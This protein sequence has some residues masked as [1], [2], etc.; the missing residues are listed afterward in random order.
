MRFLIAHNEYGAVSG[1]EHAI[2]AIAALLAKNGNN[3][4]WF[5][6]SSAEIRGVPGKIRAFVS[7]IHSHESVRGMRKFLNGWPADI[8]IVQNL[9]PFLSP[10]ILKVFREFNI[11]VIMRC[12]NYRLFCPNG[13]HLSHGEIC[14]RCLGGRE[15][16][17]V[18]RNCE[19]DLL[20]SVSY[21]LRNVAARI[22][23][24]I[25]DNV[26][27]FIVLSE[28]QKKRF[29]DAGIPPE[30][31]E[32]L[33]N[34]APQS[35]RACSEELG[36]TVSFVGR[37][38]PEKGI[39]DFLAAADRL[40]EIPFVIAGN[41]DQIPGMARRSPKNVRWLGYLKGYN[42]DE[43][44]RQSRIVVVPSRCFEGFPNVITQAMM[45]GKP[46]IASRLGSIPEI[47]DNGRT[48]LLFGPG[49][50]S[51]LVKNIQCLYNDKVWCFRLGKAGRDKALNNYSPQS[52]Y[53]RMMGII[54]RIQRVSDGPLKI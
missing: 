44:Y 18:I 13:L 15:H 31:L 7:G 4:R 19:N 47:V 37:I 28:F 20:K 46:V 11:P 21:A 6:R 22:K 27:L 8:A 30:R 41:Y 34:I 29:I 45:S 49:N 1:E 16:W 40:P 53:T 48:G 39:K 14:E 52:V 26:S 42:L 33:P 23:R 10:S 35:G 9:Y 24:R 5:L 51:E 12:P 3:V 25:V 54:N 36:V 38:S 17:C 50:V 2:R 32:I 43:F